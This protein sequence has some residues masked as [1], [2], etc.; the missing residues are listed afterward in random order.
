MKRGVTEEELPEG[1]LGVAQLCGLD[2]GK[3]FEWFVV[4]RRI[5]D[6]FLPQFHGGE[7][8]CSNVWLEH[9]SA[10]CSSMFLSL[11]CCPFR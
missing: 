3:L 10:K 7:R 9:I 5:S 6:S 2:H 11:G 1:F 4:L 8:S